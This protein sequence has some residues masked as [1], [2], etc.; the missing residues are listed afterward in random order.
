MSSEKNYT[1]TEFTEAFQRVKKILIDLKTIKNKGK[2]F[3]ELDS[4]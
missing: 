4:K 3:K 2:G 1:N